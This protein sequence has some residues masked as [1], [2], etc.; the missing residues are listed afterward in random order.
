MAVSLVFVM[1]P[2][3]TTVRLRVAFAAAA[4]STFVVALSFLLA[5]ALSHRAMPMTAS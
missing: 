1:P 4:T 5:A 3:I 2:P